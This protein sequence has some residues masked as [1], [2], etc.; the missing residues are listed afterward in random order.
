MGELGFGVTLFDADERPVVKQGIDAEEWGYSIFWAPEFLSIPTMEP[1]AVLSAVA[2]HTKSIK[3]GTGIAGLAVRSPVQMAK[4]AV[5]TDVLSNGR[6]VLGLGLGGLIPKDLEVENVPNLKERGRISN[7]RLEI[8]YRLFTERTVSHSGELYNFKDFSLGPEPVQKPRVPIWLGARYLGK[9]TEAAM[10]RAGTYADVF[11]FPADTPTTY[12][13]YAKNKI[14][15]YAEAAGRDPDSVGY[16]STMWT[17]LG[18]S[19]EKATEVANRI[20]P[21]MLSVPWKVP[22]NACYGM[23]TPEDCI[24]TAEEFADLGVSHLIMNPCCDFEDV[25]AQTEQFGREVI[26]HFRSG[27][28]S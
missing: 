26:P 13:P 27:D 2:Q 6:L 21:E 8:L 15:S 17:C 19:K 18:A 16:A 5:T 22:D 10:K 11:I 7:E 4:A 14:R 20:I 24:A 3:L 23:G 1:F 28:A 12:Y 9:I 25:T